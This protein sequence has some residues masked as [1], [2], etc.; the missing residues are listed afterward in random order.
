LIIDTSNALC[1]PR[2]LLGLRLSEGRFVINRNLWVS[3]AGAV[4]GGHRAAFVPL[5]SDQD[6]S[7]GSVEDELWLY[8]PSP[9]RSSFPFSLRREAPTFPAW[10][11]AA[12]GGLLS[13][14]AARV[15]HVVLG[16]ALG[17]RLGL[18]SSDHRPETY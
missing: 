5:S 11:G 2:F 17:V 13:L 10:S 14:R 15:T 7:V 16:V 9:V 4:A 1:G 8:L 3:A 18:R 6:G 12:A